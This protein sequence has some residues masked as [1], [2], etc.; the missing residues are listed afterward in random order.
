[1]GVFVTNLLNTHVQ[2]LELFNVGLGLGTIYYSD[3]RMFG[4]QIKKT[5]GGE[6]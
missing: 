3:P 4:F 6:H 1:M 2:N 5:F